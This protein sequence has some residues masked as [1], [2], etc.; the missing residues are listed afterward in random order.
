MRTTTHNFHCPHHLRTSGTVQE[1]ERLE[2]SPQKLLVTKERGTNWRGTQIGERTVTMKF[3]S[4]LIR[5][6]GRA[7]VQLNSDTSY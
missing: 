1:K 6:S 2:P 3:F 7:S 5:Q 4:C